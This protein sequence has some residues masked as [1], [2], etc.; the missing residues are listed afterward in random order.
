LAAG[1]PGDASRGDRGGRSEWQKARA[2]EDFGRRLYHRQI[3]SEGFAKTVELADSSRKL[4]CAENY[5][6]GSLAGM[7]AEARCATKVESELYLIIVIL[8]R[9]HFKNSIRLDFICS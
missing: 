2:G 4:S 5:G 3:C 7:D 6:D 1:L 8:L 9:V